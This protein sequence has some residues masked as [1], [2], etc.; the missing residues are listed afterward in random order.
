MMDP[1]VVEPDSKEPPP[2][3][4]DDRPPS[5]HEARVWS[6]L[7]EVLDPE[8]PISLVDLGLICD[9]RV[10][11]PRVDVDITFTATACPCMGFIREDIT[12]RLLQETDIDEVEIHEVWDPPWTVERVSPEGRE[13]L[14]RFGVAT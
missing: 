4:A 3:G 10:A 5:E 8:I 9:V 14:R 2:A 12:T 1:R 11:G 7:R 13:A 6:A